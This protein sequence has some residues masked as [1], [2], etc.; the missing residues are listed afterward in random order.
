MDGDIQ[1]LIDYANDKGGSDNIT[2]VV[3][4]RK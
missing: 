2:A 1:E 3:L 4:Y